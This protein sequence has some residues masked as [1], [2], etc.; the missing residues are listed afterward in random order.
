[1]QDDEAVR[2]GAVQTGADRIRLALM[3]E[4]DAIG[5]GKHTVELRRTGTGPVYANMYFTYFSLEEYIK[6]A[7]LEVDFRSKTSAEEIES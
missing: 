5:T 7:G 3:L 6:K 4:G 1:M 2:V